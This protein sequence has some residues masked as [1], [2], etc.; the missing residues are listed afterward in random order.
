MRQRLDVEAARRDLGGDQQ[1]DAAGLEVGERAH[2]LWLRLVA[3]DGRGGD[4]V[5]IELLGQ[6]VGAVLG[7]C[8]DERLVDDPRP[9][10][11][12]QQLA[13]ALAVDGVDDLLDQVDGGVLGR[14]LDRCGSVEERLRQRR[15]SGSRRWR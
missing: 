13:L 5:A 2:A 15:G 14:D 3:V 4:A 12:R 8:E 7:A 1:Q 11:V 9:H 6:P 10:E